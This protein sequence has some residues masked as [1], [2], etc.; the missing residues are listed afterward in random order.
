[1]GLQAY[2]NQVRENMSD[3][4]TILDNHLNTFVFHAI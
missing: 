1:M 4:K 3:I 2:L